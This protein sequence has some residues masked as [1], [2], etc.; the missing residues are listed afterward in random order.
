MT[1]SGRF[2][3]FACFLVLVAVGGFWSKANSSHA[4]V[5][6]ENKA[7]AVPVEP[8]MHEFMEYVFQPTF[9]RLK[10]AMATAPAD[11][12]V[13]KAIK[14]DALILAEAGNLLLMREPEAD[15]ADVA[16]WIKHSVEVRGFGG[17]LYR[18]AKAKDHATARKHYE[19]M[20]E[21]CNACH[22]QFAGGE[23]IL[24]P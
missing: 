17:D 9:K 22:H 8:D 20:V 4:A 14:A 2:F 21:N 15:A 16:D 13:W 6:A 5:S 12:K 23:H 3:A 10:P 11:N 7:A 1:T 24:A 18:A 19:A